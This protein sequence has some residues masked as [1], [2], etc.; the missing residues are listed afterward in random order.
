MF[1]VAFQGMAAPDLSEVRRALR[2]LGSE[3]R[4]AKRTLLRRALAE[5]GLEAL[6]RFVE[7]PTGIGLGGENAPEISRALL[8]QAK[9]YEP[10]AVRAALVEG[11]VLLP[12]DVRRLASLP[13]RRALLG[14]VV[15]GLAAPLR[16]LVTV[17][18]GPLRGFA[19]VL[20]RLE[21]RQSAAGGSAGA[22]SS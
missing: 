3:C 17:L 20:R 6:G 12:A 21:E 5:A 13:S 11:V 8:E 9:K 7:G 16:G 15:G 19:V 4:V 14:Q 10:L 18:G 1:V 2:A 22:A